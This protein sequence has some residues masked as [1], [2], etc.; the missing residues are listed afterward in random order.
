MLHNATSDFSDNVL[1]FLCEKCICLLLFSTLFYRTSLPKFLYELTNMCILY[2]HVYLV[3][4]FLI[5]CNQEIF[6]KF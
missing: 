1:N 4:L 5:Q 2:I 6:K 3:S